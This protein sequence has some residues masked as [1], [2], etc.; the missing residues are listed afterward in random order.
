MSANNN[1]IQSVSLKGSAVDSADG[2]PLCA[3]HFC[4]LPS[5]TEFYSGEKLILT[6]KDMGSCEIFPQTV[7]HNCNGR[8]LVIC[9]DGEY[10]IYTSQA[11]RNKAFGQ[12]LD[13]VWSAVGHATSQFISSD[14]LDAE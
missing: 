3:C 5:T 11:L 7:Q 1:D 10:I 8:F 14:C 12:A 9:G 13:F 2:S 6:M 4:C